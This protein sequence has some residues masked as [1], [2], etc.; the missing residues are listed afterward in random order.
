MALPMPREDPVTTATLPARR[1]FTCAL[2]PACFRISGSSRIARSLQSGTVGTSS[3]ARNR[4][5][6]EQESA[7]GAS[8][9][10]AGVSSFH[11]LLCLRE[12]AIDHLRRQLAGVR[13]LLAHVVAAEQRR[14]A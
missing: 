12:H 3:K 10:S 6:A 7:S 2:S 1:L 11:Q 4:K 13:V 14:P 8:A 5:L 9:A